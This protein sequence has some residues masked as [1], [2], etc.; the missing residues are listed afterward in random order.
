MPYKIPPFIFFDI[1]SIRYDISWKTRSHTFIIAH[2]IEKVNVSTLLFVGVRE[3]IILNPTY[4]LYFVRSGLIHINNDGD[5]YR[6]VGGYA[7]SWSRTT[8]TRLN[9]GR[10]TPSAFFLQSTVNEVTP[11]TG[12]NSRWLS[13]PLCCRSKLIVSQGGGY[14]NDR[15]V[16]LM[17]IR[18]Y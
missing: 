12:P 2:V 6:H 15:L 1:S 14:S 7:T 8:S 17:D 4:P 3:K 16:R 5:Q 18:R 9:S 13:R 11:S 10:A